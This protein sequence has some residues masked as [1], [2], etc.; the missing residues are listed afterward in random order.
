MKAIQAL[1]V[2]SSVITT[3]V[4][5]VITL[6]IHTILRIFGANCDEI[7]CEK[8]FLWKI[9]VHFPLPVLLR[10]WFQ[11]TNTQKRARKR[12][13][14]FQ[15]EKYVHN[16]FEI[17]TSLSD[18]KNVASELNTLESISSRCWNRF[19]RILASVRNRWGLWTLSSTIFSIG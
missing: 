8:R 4:S 11:Q 10:Q 1:E 5:T 2:V 9:R 6:R 13:V 18:H 12:R 16:V 3:R 14:R 15:P 7:W 17:F 19:I